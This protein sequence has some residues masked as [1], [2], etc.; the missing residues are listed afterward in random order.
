MRT[1]L[2]HAF[3]VAQRQA[4]RLRLNLNPPDSRPQ[5]KLPILALH[6]IA[7]ANSDMA[8][9]E[10]SLRAQLIGLLESGYLCLTLPEA[11]QALT[12]GRP[13]HQP[14]FC[15]T[16]DDGYRTL[17]DPG[18]RILED[19]D[20]KAT[21]FVT[22][23]F[24]DNQVRPPWH[25]RDAALLREYTIHAEQFQPLTWPQLSELY[26]TK[27]VHIGSHSLNHY[28]TG[29]L[30]G[31]DLQAEIRDS[32]SALEDRLG[33][34]VPYFAYPYGVSR[35]GAYSGRSEAAVREA[36]YQCSCTSEIGRATVGAGAWLLPRIP[37]V[38]A[39]TALD[40]RA[41]AAGAYDWVALAQ[42]TFQNIFPNPHNPE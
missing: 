16:F 27:R 8:V 6:T 14:A 31:P 28:M 23:N 20:L 34:E 32:K 17:Y 3:Y 19:L 25:S 39:D 21:V 9:S 37:L 15:L 10:P 13:L 40:A 33:I 26:A 11:L 1:A 24:I 36:G 4:A 22:V 7:E 18:L 38:N 42:R 2:K 5:N 41:K 12:A 30:P 29:N 35:Y